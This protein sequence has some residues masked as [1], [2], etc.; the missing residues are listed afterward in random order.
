MSLEEDNY[1]LSFLVMNCGSLADPTNGQVV[2]SNGSTYGSVATYIC[3]SGYTLSGSHLRTC[4]A[5]GNWRD[6]SPA[7][8]SKNATPTMFLF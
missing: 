5:D 1:L 3:D 8:Y 2:I 6:T 4:R 7:C